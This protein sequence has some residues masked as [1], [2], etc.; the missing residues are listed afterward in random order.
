[1]IRLCRSLLLILLCH[2]QKIQSEQENITTEFKI[3]ENALEEKRKKIAEWKSLVEVEVAI[4]KELNG[5]L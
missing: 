5:V 2:K 3:E 1:M 4:N